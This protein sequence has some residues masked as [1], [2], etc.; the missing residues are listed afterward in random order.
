M[1]SQSVDNTISLRNREGFEQSVTSGP[2]SGVRNLDDNERFQIS[3]P[4][5]PGS[6]GGR[7]FNDRGEVITIVVSYFRDGQNLNFAIPANLVLPLLKD[8]SEISLTS[9][10]TPARESLQEHPRYPLQSA[11][12]MRSRRSGSPF[13]NACNGKRDYR[14]TRKVTSASFEVRTR[15]ASNTARRGT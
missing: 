10:P 6:S 14:A 9:L 12:N 3:A 13:P 11:R 4:I 1:D 7:V 2:V 8:A 15:L 5:S